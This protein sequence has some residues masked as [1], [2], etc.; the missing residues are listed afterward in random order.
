MSNSFPMASSLVGGMEYINS[1]P[2]T[3]FLINPFD[4]WT[5]SGN[6]CFILISCMKILCW[7]VLGVK[8]F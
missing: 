8:K 4:Q 3:V 6:K 1:L 2:N 7:N 5:Q